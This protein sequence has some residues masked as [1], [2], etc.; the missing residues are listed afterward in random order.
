MAAAKRSS[1]E[2]RYPVI[3]TVGA[4]RQIAVEMASPELPSAAQSWLLTHAAVKRF[5]FDGKAA[6]LA[7][8]P[9]I[10]RKAAECVG[11]GNLCDRGESEWTRKDFV[12]LYEQLAEREQKNRLHPP[13]LKAMVEGIGA[14]P[15]LLPREPDTRDAKQV[16]IDAGIL[17][18]PRPANPRQLPAPGRNGPGRA[19][20][21]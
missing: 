8:L 10:V 19:C 18:R 2:N 1:L 11:W 21:R 15:D 4:L 9:P 14:A 20:R 7:S 6:G 17:R 16:L 3:P 13:A 5:G 12:K